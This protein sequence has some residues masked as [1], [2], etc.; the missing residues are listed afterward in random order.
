MISCITGVPLSARR[1][2]AGAGP[3][4]SVLPASG[5]HVPGRSLR[6]LNLTGSLEVARQIG[7]AAAGPLKPLTLELGGKSEPAARR[8]RPHGRTG[9]PGAEGQQRHAGTARPGTPV[10]TRTFITARRRGLASPSLLPRIR[11]LGGRYP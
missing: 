8:N 11:R 1:P 4:R 3:G 5:V 6:T 9:Q 7:R 10:R 2:P